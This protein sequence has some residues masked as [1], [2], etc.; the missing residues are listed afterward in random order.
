MYQDLSKFFLPP[1]ERGRPK[2][3]IFLW[4][5]VQATLW[6]YSPRPLYG[7]R[8]FLLRIF[9]ADIGANVLIRPTSKITYPWNIEIGINSW[10]GDD[11]TLYSLGKI[12]IGANVS[13]A[14]DVYLC[15]G[16]HD[17]SSLSFSQKTAPI[18]IEDQCWLPNDIFVGPGVTI[19]LGCV[20]GA[21]S[22]IFNDLPS[23]MIC[24][25][26]PAKPVR[27]RKPS[28]QTQVIQS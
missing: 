26:N 16:S 20:V 3:F 4:M 22:S 8:R 5:I 23:G 28:T 21:R 1:S 19:G 6:R 9:G 2:W 13:I 27:P 17:Y 14:H 25:G 12:Q 10:I 15:T 18:K 11:C 7:W 24:Y